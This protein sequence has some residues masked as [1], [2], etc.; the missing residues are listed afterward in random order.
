MLSRMEVENKWSYTSVFLCAFV[1]RTGTI[2]YFMIFIYAVS[3]SYVWATQ[4]TSSFLVAGPSPRRPR[5]DLR[6]VRVGFVVY[7]YVVALAHVFSGYF[8]FPCQY[9]FTSAPYS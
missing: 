6:P 2:I 9:H 4:N 5:F 7:G 8:R 3:I 1:E